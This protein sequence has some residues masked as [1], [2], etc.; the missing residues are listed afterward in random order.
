MIKVPSSSALAELTGR[1]AAPAPAPAAPAPAPPAVDSAAVAA[2]QQA[3]ATMA[4]S[5]ATMANA[6]AANRPEPPAQQLNATIIRDADNR[7]SHLEVQIIR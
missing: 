1:K 6:I 5:M 4:G 2:L 7:I 3:M